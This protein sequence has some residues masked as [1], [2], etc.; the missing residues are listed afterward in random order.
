MGRWSRHV[1]PSGHWYW[2][3][4][5]KGESTYDEPDRPRKKQ[6]LA[7]GNWLVA[8]RQGKLLVWDPTR[9][10]S[11]EYQPD[12]APWD[13]AVTL[14]ARARGL[15]L[16]KLKN[17]VAPPEIP[18][19]R[20]LEHKQG[21]SRQAKKRKSQDQQAKT[22]SS[23][24]ESKEPASPLTESIPANRLNSPKE[25]SPAQHTDSDPSSDDDNEEEFM[26]LLDD[27]QPDPLQ[28]WESNRDKL[29][30]DPRY[31]AL[32][33]NIKRANSFAKWAKPL[34]NRSASRED[35]LKLVWACAQP[36]M[37]YLEFKR[38]FRNEPGFECELADKQKEQLYREYQRYIKKSA[39]DRRRYL[40]LLKSIHNADEYL[41]SD[42][43]WIALPPRDKQEF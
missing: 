1:S 12:D 31:L 37:Y 28:P 18:P 13:L 8:T 15:P 2:H 17:P 34:R 39:D 22:V 6:I 25:A 23:I 41:E 5:S 19:P 36:S 11:R 21:S 16:E 4:T 27:T 14:I 40:S 33:S 29:A 38:Q 9:R 42:P 3:N 24:K 43:R 7:S 20:T 32:S 10:K 35:Y 26:E 30:G